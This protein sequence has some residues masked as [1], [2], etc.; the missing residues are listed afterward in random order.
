MKRQL[1]YDPGTLRQLTPR[2]SIVLTAAKKNQPVDDIA[3]ALH[4]PQSLVIR[5]LSNIITKL[6]ESD[7]K[8][9][10]QLLYSYNIDSSR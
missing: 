7:N 4:I 10:H 6:N 5:H 1:F 8:L 9:A 3:N 2:E